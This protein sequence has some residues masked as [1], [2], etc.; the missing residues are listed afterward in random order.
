MMKITPLLLVAALGIG[1][2]TKYYR[3]TDTQTG[4]IYV[5]NSDKFKER[6]SG[7]VQF[8]DLATNQTVTL[9][10]YEYLEITK[11]QAHADMKA[12]K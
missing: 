11:D 4:K 6:G 12:K 10:S 9:Q 7:A 2:C 1:G 8:K 5:A 3:V